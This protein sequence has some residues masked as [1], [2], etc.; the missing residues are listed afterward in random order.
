MNTRR[1][2]A[3]LAAA[4]ALLA[5]P[6]Y[7]VFG[8]A[9]D[10]N[11]PSQFQ[12]SNQTALSD[13]FTYQG[14]LTE[15]NQPANGTY[16]FQF[17]LFGAASGSAQVCTVAANDIETRDDVTVANGVFTVDLDFCPEAFDGDARWLEIAVRNG[18]ATGVYTVLSPRQPISP[19]PYA[20][21]AKRTGSLAVPFSASGASTGANSVFAI[22]QNGTTNP[23]FAL[24]A[25][26][27]TGS[28]AK[29]AGD[30]TGI[31]ID[32]PIKVSGTKSAFQV[33]VETGTGENVCDPTGDP[34]TN[35]VEIPTTVANAATD[36]LFVTAVGEVSST[37]G[38]V[39]DDAACADGAWIIYAHDDTS[40]IDGQVFNVLVIKQ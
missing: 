34:T 31:E 6:V 18:T 40:M 8:G 23:G 28:G 2:I 13:S 3:I 36:M 29:V 5:L 26:G 7:S 39:F 15:T 17:T 35:G 9:D 22:T 1:P 11:P 12:V 21:Y 37:F 24:I 19:T 27:S 33:T 38:V 10:P 20:I 30:I 16:D 4:A 25:D 32:G 14:R